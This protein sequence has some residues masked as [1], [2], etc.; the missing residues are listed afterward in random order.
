MK[1]CIICEQQNDSNS[2]EHIV[3]ESFG[4]NLYVLEKGDVC[5]GCNNRFSKFETKALSHTVFAIER[6]RFAVKTK[7]GKY[8]RGRVNELTFVGDEHFREQLIS[9]GGLNPR[10]AYDFDPKKGTFKLRVETFEKSCVPTGRLLLKM[11]IEAI[12]KSKPKLFMNNDFTDLRNYLTNRS[13]RDWPFITSNKEF[14]SFFNIPGTFTTKHLKNNHITLRASNEFEDELLFKFRYG[15]IGMIINLLN[16]GL[17]WI[18]R[19]R[20]LDQDCYIYP[21]RIEQLYQRN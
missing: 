3:S 5:D 10:N 8:V 9:I 15:S 11:G 12:F 19:Y 21:E 2:V 1:H 4:N 16:R 6:A 14:G 7:K 13:N 20:D 18:Y 17:N